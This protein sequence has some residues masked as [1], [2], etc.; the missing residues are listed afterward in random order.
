MIEHQLLERVIAD[1]PVVIV[2]LAAN[3]MLWKRLGK[4]ED[5]LIKH[6]ER[7]HDDETDQ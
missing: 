4:L 1:V 5:A 7:H 6:L 2:L 3:G